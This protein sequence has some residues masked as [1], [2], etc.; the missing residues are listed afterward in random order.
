M[1]TTYYVAGKIGFDGLFPYGANQD[2][3]L[4]YGVD[5]YAGLPVVALDAEQK[6]VRAKSGLELKYDQ[7]LI[8]TGASPVLPPVEGIS[9]ARVYTMRIVEDAI[10]L[11]EAMAKKP[12][13]ALVIGASMVG[14][15]VAELKRRK[16]FLRSIRE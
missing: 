11:K 6:V 7:C 2:Y 9:S 14:I 8:A 15:K 13:K 16:D 1:L 3:Y 5:V 12:K 10:R 4:R